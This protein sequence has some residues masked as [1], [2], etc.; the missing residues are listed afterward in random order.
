MHE[1]RANRVTP[2]HVAPA[3]AIRVMLKEQVV[4]A[5]VKHEPVRVVVPSAAGREM[6]LPPKR[7]AVK[8]CSPFDSIALLDRFE[9]GGI[10]EQFVHLKSDGFASP[11][12]DVHG[13]PRIG[14]GI[15]ELNLIFDLKLA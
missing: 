13:G 1:V 9:A 12:A 10:L 5:A 3:P 8:I 4:F 2:M 6:E 7:L 14:F 15:G 11:G